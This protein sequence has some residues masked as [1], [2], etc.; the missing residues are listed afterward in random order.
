MGA[1]D[2]RSPSLWLN[3][4]GLGRGAA[5]VGDDAVILQRDR[6]IYIYILEGKAGMLVRNT[7]GW[8]HPHCHLAR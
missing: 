6:V 1:E 8:A 5:F 3:T 7:R 4:G 2:M